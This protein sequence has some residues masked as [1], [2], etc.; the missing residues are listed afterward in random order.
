MYKP[1]ASI[2]SMTGAGIRYCTLQKSCQAFG[3]KTLRSTYLISRLKNSLI[4]V[5]ET[6][7]C[8]T[9]QAQLGFSLSTRR[10][11]ERRGYHTLLDHICDGWVVSFCFIITNFKLRHNSWGKSCSRFTKGYIERAEILLMNQS[12]IRGIYRCCPSTVK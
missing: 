12:G 1:W 8:I 5:L 6:S 4:L 11:V 10:L 9:I 3:L 2:Y 7:F